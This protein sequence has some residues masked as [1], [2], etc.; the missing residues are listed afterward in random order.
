MKAVNK[1]TVSYR[2]FEK[3]FLDKGL[4]YPVQLSAMERGKAIN[5]CQRLNRLH[6]H[7]AE[8]EGVPM[9]GISAKA[10]EIGGEGEKTWTVEVSWS[11]LNATGQRGQHSPE[12]MHELLKVELKPAVEIQNATSPW[13]R[14]ELEMIAESTGQS[15]E[16]ILKFYGME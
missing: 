7:W 13:T 8:E 5:L 10:K 3:M 15:L 12:W 6:R 2:I 4:I 9:K 14:E 16:E 11:E 1:L